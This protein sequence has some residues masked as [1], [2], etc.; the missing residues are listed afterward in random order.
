MMGN[1]PTGKKEI[2]ADIAANKAILDYLFEDSAHESFLFPED[3]D[4]TV[5]FTAGGTDN[6]F[7]AWVEIVDNNAVT[8]SSKFTTDCGHISSISARDTSVKDEEYIFEI[9]YGVSNIVVAR[10]N[11]L[12]ATVLI[13]GIQQDRMRNLGV[14]AGETVYYRMKCETASATMQ[15]RMRY[16]CH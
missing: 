1:D 7:G 12:S 3:T 2:L 16:H 8:L 9:S 5:T 13:P 4:E 14:P 10:I 15:V 11:L 6:T